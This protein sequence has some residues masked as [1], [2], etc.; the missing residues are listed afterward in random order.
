MALTE[1]RGRDTDTQEGP[2]V[3]DE[4]DRSTE[5]CRHQCLRNNQQAKPVKMEKQQSESLR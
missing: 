2:S 1:P 3:R 5:P 4:Q